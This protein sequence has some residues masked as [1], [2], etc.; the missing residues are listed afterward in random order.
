MFFRF[1]SASVT[2]SERLFSEW[3]K[4]TTD[5]IFFYGNKSISPLHARGGPG[6][7]EPLLVGLQGVGVQKYGVVIR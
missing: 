1:S 7:A 3:K 5:V 2:F 4:L 6:G